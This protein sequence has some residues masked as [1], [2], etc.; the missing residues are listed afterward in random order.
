VLLRGDDALAVRCGAGDLTVR[1]G[2]VT[3]RV[4][5]IDT[6]DS[7]LWVSGDLSLADE[8]LKLVARVEPKDW[9]PLALRTPVHIGGTFAQPDIS[10]EKG[11][12]A[13]RAVPAALL[14]MIAP[15]AA[16]LPL[17]D[18]GDTQ[19]ADALIQECRAVVARFGPKLV[20][21]G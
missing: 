12:L 20:G 2:K 3:P 5:L 1:D 7:M 15:L 13:K 19:R 11:P 21:I 18:H 8:R 9:S 14:A 10:I 17:I 16:L 4:L 6:R